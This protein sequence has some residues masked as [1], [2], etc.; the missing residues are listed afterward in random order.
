MMKYY[1][2]VLGLIPA[3][4]ITAFL[5]YFITGLSWTVTVPTAATVSALVIGHALFINPPI[6]GP[7]STQDSPVHL[8]D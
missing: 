3:M 8:T 7:Q 4:F 6:T 2:L 5:L 1:D